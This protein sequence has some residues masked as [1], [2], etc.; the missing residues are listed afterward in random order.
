MTLNYL[1]CKKGLLPFLLHVMAP[2][3]THATTF[4]DLFAGTGAVSAALKGRVGKVISNDAEQ[5]SAVIN[6]ALL[7]CPFSHGLEEKISLLNALN[8]R[9]GRV[10][11]LYSLQRLFFSRANAMKIDACR[12]ELEAWRPSISKSDYTFLLASILVAADQVANTACVYA[13]H[14]KTLKPA[15][16]K[17]FIIV[18]LHRD[19]APHVEHE[20]HR[21]DAQDLATQRGFD[22]VYLD[23]PYNHRQYSINYSFLNF[24]ARYDTNDMVTGVGG[25]MTDRF[26]SKFCRR[27][28]AEKAVSDLVSSLSAKHIFMSYNSEGIVPLDKLEGILSGLGRVT[29][30]E[31]ASKRFKSAKRDEPHKKK[32]TEFLFHLEKAA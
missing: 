4:G 6:E 18:P 12:T 17:D 29:R 1:G 32:V 3:L 2:V 28:H 31:M 11:Q 8:G 20:A 25:I 22:V 26:R 27:R 19:A 23:P 9:D 15:A 30:H 10:T 5:Y 7:C 24:L 16:Q 21:G 14:L 13:S